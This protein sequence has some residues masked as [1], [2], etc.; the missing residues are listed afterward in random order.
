MT[1]DHIMSVSAVIITATVIAG[2]VAHKLKLGSTVAL[3]TVGMALGPHAPTPLFTGHVDELQA[4]GQVGVVLLLFL[5]GLD[6]QP[7]RLLSMRRLIFGL[8]TAQYLL[9]T[10]VITG[11][12]IAVTPL[13][14]QTALLVGLG[15]AMS[16]D[17]VG[18][19]SVE[20]RGDS[21]SAHGQAVL[22]VVINQNF[23]AILVL[24]AVPIL[25]AGPAPQIPT[26]TLDK[27]LAV[28]AA[29]ATVYVLGRYGLPRALTWAARKR[30][31]EVFMLI[32]I[33]AVFA[34]AWVMDTVGV[35]SAL[36]S[37]M[38]GMTLSTSVFA[39]Q[40]KAAVSLTKGLLLRVFFIAIGMAINVKEV[41]GLGSLVLLS[42]PT[43]FLIKIVVVM[44]LARL[45]RFGLRPAILAGVLLM[46]FDEIGYV[47]FASAHGSGLLTDQ[48]YTMGL[49]LISCSFILSPVLIN[50]GYKLADRFRPELKPTLSPK[51]LSE[52]I[53][54]HVVVVGYSYVGRAV[55][56]MLERA[57]VPYLAFERDLERLADGRK[58]QH[59]VHYGDVTD[60]TM[61]SAVA[62][63]RARSVVVTM[64]DYIA[65]KRMIGTPRQFYPHVTVMTAVPYLFQRD[66]LRHMGATQVVALTPEGELSF[67][68]SLLSGLG[69]TT[70]E[71]D[72]II[73]SLRADDYAVLRGVVGSE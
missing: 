8:G 10:G 18:I 1:T 50:L 42:L 37:L 47:I 33:A 16:S 49:T 44:V 4:V 38:I 46:P 62:I 26:P 43:L 11:L 34:A 45:F 63:A 59:K 70:D 55:C 9:T 28:I 19:S 68:R 48:A 69:I 23:M 57:N 2:G 71:I 22:A 56:I 25:A 64:R 52:P 30:G 15:L 51:E 73:D 14:W 53:Q 20:E 29:V 58:R 27:A 3:L 6:S 7:Q 67:G 13:P 54:D 5:V 41:A 36:G 35:S 72:M 40:I 12:L 39:E 31:F 65:I 17:A 60:P 66:E 32:I 61:M 24:A 21:T